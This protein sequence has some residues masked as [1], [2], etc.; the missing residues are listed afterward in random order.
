MNFVK[1]K[2]K[3]LIKNAKIINEGSIIESDLLMS[4]ELIEKLDS[5]IS[6][7]RAEVIDANGKYL[8]PGIID[9]QVHFREPGL[10]H[11]ANIYTESKAAVAG[12]VTSYMEMP[13]TKP[14]ALTIEELEK[15]YSI[16]E[17]DS[18]AN[19]SFFMGTSNE[20]ADEALKIDPKN[21]CGIK[22]F[23]GSSTGNMLV[24]DTETLEKI[25]C[26]NPSITLIHSED[27]HI[28][29]DNLR[30]FKEKYGED[31]PFDAHPTIRSEKACLKSTIKAMEIANKCNGRLHILHITTGKEA[32]LFDNT[33][34]LK[35]KNIT[36][37]VCV[38][39]L[40]YD[41]DDYAEYGSLIKCNPAIKEAK[42]KE[43]IFQAL[44]DNKIDVIASDHAP[45]TWQEKSG[46][47]LTAPSGI[48]LV[49]HTLNVMLE[50]YHKGMISLERIVEKMSHAVA[51]LFRI[52]KRGYIK[53]GY[54]AD[55]ALLDLNKNWEVNKYNI[56]YKCA[57]SPFEGKSFTGKITD[58]FVSGHHAYKN[59]YF[60]EST[61][62]KRLTFK[63]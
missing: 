15:K 39:H 36:A 56:D 8:I 32:L 26:N 63:Y 53:E 49:S 13:N 9:D 31:I 21:I 34:P 43:I 2:N 51:D 62:G 4:G 48:P 61:K 6:D 24:D 22:V 10:T 18:L 5:N 42:N 11:K 33:K 17:I 16:A 37:E 45:H 58:T 40:Y 38:H 30:K 25:F 47:Y 52:E 29:N 44:L 59:G 1:P 20:N 23:M 7:S 50:F 14:P 57:W 55:L 28:I 46:K 3:T 12:G 35:E 19:Y 27:E 54:F 41:S 60:D